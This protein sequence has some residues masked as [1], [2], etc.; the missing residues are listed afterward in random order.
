MRLRALACVSGFV[1]GVIWL[2]RALLSGDVV[3]TLYWVGLVLLFVA[4]VGLGVGLVSKGALW[5]QAIVGLAFPLLVWSV[6]EVLHA[7]GD[8]VVVDAVVGVAIAATCV[9]ALVRLRGTDRPP[10]PP[11]PPKRHAGAHAR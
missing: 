11:K 2:V 6:V 8:G 4:L 7:D 1:G 10:K 5:L 9:V 3:D